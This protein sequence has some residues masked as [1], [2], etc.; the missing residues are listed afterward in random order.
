MTDPMFFTRGSGPLVSCL[1]PSRGNPVALRKAVESLISLAA[2][3]NQ[4]EII[5]KV[6][7]DDEETFKTALYLSENSP[8]YIKVISSPRGHGYFEIHNWLNQMAAEA[9]GDWLFILNDDSVMETKDWDELLCH[10]SV[11]N[12]WHNC[13]QDIMLL[14]V[15]IPNRPGAIDFFLLRRKVYELTG[16][17]CQSPYGDAW[18]K[19]VMQIIECTATAGILKM[20]HER[21]EREG[22]FTNSYHLGTKTLASVGACM[23]KTADAY[24]LLAHIEAHESAPCWTTGPVAPGWQ[25]WRQSPDHDPRHVFVLENGTVMV[26]ATGN[27]K[28]HVHE[29]GGMWQARK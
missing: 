13:P 2:D 7:N 20:Q 17:V 12:C 28:S 18:V 4:V 14:W 22:R 29:M 16:H 19:Q 21:T 26:S 6:D 24:R 10:A 11:E 15:N 5:L 23:T 27:I 8:S 1:I 9:R 25:R 3:P